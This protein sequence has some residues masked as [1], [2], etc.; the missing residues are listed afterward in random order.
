MGAACQFQACC[1]RH[2][3]CAVKQA[4]MPQSHASGEVWQKWYLEVGVALLY[5]FKWKTLLSVP[6]RLFVLYMFGLLFMWAIT[7]TTAVSLLCGR[8]ALNGVHA[9]FDMKG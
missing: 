8:L 1:C 9:C 3:I 4:C 7:F 5:A 6:F 2:A